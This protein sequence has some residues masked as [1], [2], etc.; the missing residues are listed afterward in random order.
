MLH[1]WVWRFDVT[2]GGGNILGRERGL[3]PSPK[4]S[5]AAI[6]FSPAATSH[7]RSSFSSRRPTLALSTDSKFCT[8]DNKIAVPNTSETC[9]ASIS[10]RRPPICCPSQTS[11]HPRRIHLP[12]RLP[13]LSGDAPSPCDEQHAPSVPDNPSSWASLPAQRLSVHIMPPGRD[14]WNQSGTN[15]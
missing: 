4:F 3:R 5:S 1:A 12:P 9:L 6:F 7:A 14:G 8:R 11:R 2:G 10:C 15:R 13:S